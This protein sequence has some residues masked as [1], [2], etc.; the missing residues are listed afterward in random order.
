[1]VWHRHRRD[2][3]SLSNQAYGYGVGLG[4]YL[5]IGVLVEAAFLAG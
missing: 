1:M 3:E 4:A 5:L 2:L